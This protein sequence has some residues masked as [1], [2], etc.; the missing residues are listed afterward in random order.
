MPRLPE[1]IQHFLLRE[2]ATLRREVEA[3]PDEESIWA[4]PPGAPN[5]GG[6][7]VLHLAGN[8]QHYIGA[9]LGDTGYVRDRDAEFAAR[10][11]SQARLLAEITAAESAVRSALPRVRDEQLDE[12]FPEAL[13][14][15]R[16]E[17]GDFLLQVVVHM[18]YHLGQLSYHRRLVTGDSRG[19]DALAPDRLRTARRN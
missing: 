18:G 10:G 16:V 11:L 3:Y 13:R 7:L 1:M 6:T 19:V 8:I 9:L 5:S 2:L 4:L 12:P 14:G 17:T 15:Y